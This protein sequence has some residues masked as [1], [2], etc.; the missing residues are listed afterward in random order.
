M[1]G[2]VGKD[3]QN[4]AIFQDYATGYLYLQNLIKYK[5]NQN[6]NQNFYAFF[7]VY[8]PSFENDSKH[9]AEVVAKACG[10]KA[11]DLVS[12]IL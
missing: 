6:P 1:Y 7:E 8:A 11:T 10:M 12:K 5:I 9:Y 2:H 4:F 3:P